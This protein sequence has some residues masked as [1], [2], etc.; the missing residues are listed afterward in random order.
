MLPAGSA[1]NGEQTTMGD[2]PAIQRLL[3]GL[4]LARLG[5]ERP[6][7]LCVASL[8]LPRQAPDGLGIVGA[9]SAALPLGQW[10]DAP[11]PRRLLLAADCAGAAPAAL[12]VARGAEPAGGSL[13]RA[14]MR[15]FE[16][17]PD[18][19]FFWERHSL[20][21]EWR[22]HCVE[23]ALGLRHEG[24]LR[25]W[26]ACNL[27]VR[28]DAPFCRVVEMGGA[29]PARMC[30]LAYLQSRQGYYD[31]EFL[32]QHNWLNGR[33]TIRL[34]ANGVCDV[35]ARH[36]NSKF[37]DDGRDL[38]H[39]VPVL[40]LRVD[41]EPPMQGAG[42]WDGSMTRLERGAAAFDFAEMARLA[43][44]EKPGEWRVEQG[45]L[46]VQPYLG[47]ELYGGSA[48]KALSGDAYVLRGEEQRVLRGMARSLR[49]SFSLNPE[50]V[51]GIVRYAPPAW[52]YGVCEEFVP[53]ALLPVRTEL[54][55]ACD[56]GREWCRQT[57]RR[58]GFEDGAMPRG[59][60]PEAP[61]PHEPGWEGE[62]PYAQF[63]SA[64]A[65]GD[66]AEY[67][68]AMRAAYYFADVCIDHAAK[69]VRMHGWP[70]NAFALPMARVHACLAAY[71]ETGDLFLRQAAE[72]VI[73]TAYWMHKNS[74]PRMAVGRDAC[75]IRGAVLLY[76]YFGGAHYR[77][78]ARDSL[79]DVAASQKPDGS[80]G[81]QG[82][83]AGLHAWA[84]YITKPW[85]GCMAVGGAIDWLELFPDDAETA[86][87]VKRFADWLMR[88]RFDH[89]GVMGWSY[90]HDYRGGP[91][92]LDA[93]GKV[94]RL[95]GPG[96]WHKD[97]LARVLTFCALRFQDASYYD[98]WHESFSGAGG[99]VRDDHAFAQ[100]LQFV[101]WVEA[102]LWNAAVA[103]TG[104]R[105][106]PT[107]L[108]ERTPRQATVQT[109]DGPVSC[110]WDEGGATCRAEDD[111][112]RLG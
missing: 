31:N 93:G 64:W 33:V 18:A 48:A 49:F 53:A 5:P 54:S 97:Y 57:I 52:W 26:E 46:V 78:M 98:A 74:W 32:H 16:T 61:P 56:S 21:I 107:W 89:D 66:A 84:A 58:N 103:G 50:R 42:A 40:G 83:G 22:G 87:M 86:G 92:F 11:A 102:R 108:G 110:S 37:F 8:P 1:W 45:F 71:L 85:M 88:E 24:A 79:A 51:P 13:P 96:L 112:V 44:A 14:S 43:T 111:R 47:M 70:P 25:W 19:L 63:L 75:F 100:T 73:Q 101:P 60:A 68:D 12:T 105:A 91:D 38:P 9:P 20:A 69:Q 106:E 72:S 95:P 104:V 10:H 27:V 109:P 4:Q 39:T 67:D 35:V 2:S 76:R 90:Q 59:A 65:T 34:H 36:V 7:G 28:E 29:I 81:D 62:V 3:Q 6:G 80:F 30:D 99:G 17:A 55:A 77:D 23:L 15:L 94:V 41:G 82:G